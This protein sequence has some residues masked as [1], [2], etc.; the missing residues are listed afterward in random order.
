MTDLTRH[1]TRRSADRGIPPL[2]I[3]WL[4]TYGEEKYDGRGGVIRFYRWFDYG[5]HKGICPK[6]S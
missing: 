6:G 4:R 1:A 2:I 5:W 3:E